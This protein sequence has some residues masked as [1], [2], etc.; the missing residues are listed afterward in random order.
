M[1]LFRE[2]NIEIHH[3]ANYELWCAKVIN[4]TLKGK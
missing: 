2:K 3:S 1:H 4:Y